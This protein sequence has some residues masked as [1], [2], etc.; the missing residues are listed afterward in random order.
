MR[1]REH[2]IL[3]Y[4]TGRPVRFTMDGTEL[5]GM[6]GEPI[7]SAL[8]ANGVFQFRH[9]EKAG[10][11]RGVFCGIGQCCECMVIV[12]G[13]PNVRSCITPLKEGMRVQTQ[14]GFGQIGGEL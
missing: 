14:E 7:A 2:P 11:P 12:D 5:T 13:K 10:E 9:T 6:E 1:I 4:K 8:M 3:S